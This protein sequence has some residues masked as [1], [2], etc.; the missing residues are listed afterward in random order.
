MPLPLGTT[1]QANAYASQTI[2][3]DAGGPFFES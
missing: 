2:K 1:T 3:Q